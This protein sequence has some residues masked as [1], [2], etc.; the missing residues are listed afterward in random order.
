MIVLTDTHSLVWSL[1]HKD[2]F[3]RILVAQ[4]MTEKIPLVTKDSRL[5]QYGI[6]IIW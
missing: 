1:V 3:D 2:P 5:S 4:A 6:T